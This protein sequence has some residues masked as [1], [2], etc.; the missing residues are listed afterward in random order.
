LIMTGGLLRSDLARRTAKFAAAALSVTALSFSTVLAD[1]SPRRAICHAPANLVRLAYPLTHTAQRL[2]AG[3]PLTIVAI[4]SSSTAGAGASSPGASYPSRLAAELSQRFPHNRITVI[5]QGVNGEEVR[6]MLARFPVSVIAQKPDLVLWQVGTNAVMRD[7]PLA[8]AGS[9]IRDGV[10]QVKAIG[11]DIVLMDPQFAPRVISKPEID[12]MINLLS[13]AAKEASVDM[14]P[15][16]A[17]MRFWH[18]KDGMPFD[19]FVSPDGL[20]MNDW[21]YACVA[22]LLGSAISEA[23]TR[24]TASVQIGSAAHL[25]DMIPTTH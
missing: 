1:D 14:F 13:T 10:R 3:E 21:G 23:A 25:H 5:N 15:R 24:V 7:D 4:G 20:H 6:D 18:D 19:T 12:G 2:L 11:A 8:P 17:V 22:T 16:F 9:L